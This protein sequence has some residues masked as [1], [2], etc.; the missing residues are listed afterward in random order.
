MVEE[1]EA[2][3][4]GLEDAIE[5]LLAPAAPPLGAPDVPL[6]NWK[7]HNREWVV[8]CSSL[9]PQYVSTAACSN[10]HRNTEYSWAH[11]LHVALRALMLNY[12]GVESD[13]PMASVDAG[14][15]LGKIRHT[16]ESACIS[17]A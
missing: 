8:C 13:P 11:A 2:L 1:Q 4:E 14:Q 5:Q 12:K 7:S 3:W 15:Q 17:Q 9:R 10:C 16:Y 6:V